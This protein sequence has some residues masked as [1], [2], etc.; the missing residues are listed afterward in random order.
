M[1]VKFNTTN[2][3][4]RLEYHIG[5]IEKEEKID[6]LII[7]TKFYENN[8]KYKKI[9]YSSGKEP[10]ET[11]ISLLNNTNNITYDKYYTLI[12]YGKDY[13]GDSINYFY[14]RN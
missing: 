12:A 13:Y 5:L 7:H 11:N 1:I 6:P 8:L 10:I 14:R 2:Y 4:S 9:I 3:I